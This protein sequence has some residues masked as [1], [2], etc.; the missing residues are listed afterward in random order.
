MGDTLVAEQDRGW[1][2]QGNPPELEHVA[3]VG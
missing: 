1:P 3:P 2:G